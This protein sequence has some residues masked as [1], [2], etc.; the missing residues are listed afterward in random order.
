MCA[1]R[2]TRRVKWYEENRA[3]WGKGSCG[4]AVDWRMEVTGRKVD[5]HSFL[6]FV[7]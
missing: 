5:L 2:T 6:S 3:D 7:L 4:V 1:L